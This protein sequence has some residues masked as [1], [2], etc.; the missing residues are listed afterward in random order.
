M[1]RTRAYFKA[2]PFHELVLFGVACVSGLLFFLTF[3]VWLV[4]QILIP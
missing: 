2:A 1:T 3:G 4:R